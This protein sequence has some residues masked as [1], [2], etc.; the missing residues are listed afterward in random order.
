MPDNINFQD[1]LFLDIETF[2]VVKTYDELSDEMQWLWD[3]KSAKTRSEGQT[4]AEA[5]FERAG[6]FAEYGKI[7]C[8]SAGI[9]HKSD[10]TWNFRL[11]SFAGDDEKKLLSD[12]AHMLTTHFSSEYK[13]LCGHN[14]KEFDFPYICRRM[15][16]NE[17]RIPPI[18]QIQGKKPWEVQHLDTLDLW[19]F[20]DYKNYTSLR[21]LAALF[22]I[23]TPKDDIDGSEVAGVY[24]N[25]SDL[26]RI[27]TYCEKDVLTTAR[28]FLKMAGDYSPI[29]DKNVS[30]HE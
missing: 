10:G 24:W 21:L 6:I 20:G 28:I 8:I 4:A 18:L 16:I 14:G 30:R 9:L 5:Y 27:V 22:N 15:L 23:P 11:R 13:R 26:N 19:K 1:I 7:I 25:D 12:F 29:E 3:K 17:V 2:P